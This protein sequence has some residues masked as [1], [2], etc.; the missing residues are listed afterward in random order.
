M[1]DKGSD[2]VL[3]SKKI[4]VKKYK[5]LVSK[6]DKEE[7]AQFIFERFHERY[8][9]PLKSIPNKKKNGFCIMA[10]CC[11]MIEALESFYQGWEVTSGR[12]R[13]AFENFFNRVKEFRDLKDCSSEFYEH[14]RCGILHQAETTGGW[15]IIRKGPLF[16]SN[17]LAINATEF[18]NRL[19]KYLKK[20]SDNLRSSKWNDVIWK[21]LRKKMDS[22]IKNCE[23]RQIICRTRHLLLFK[24]SGIT[25]MSLGMMG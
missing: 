18:L 4:T 1:R 17:K 11:L 24:G 16:D 22:V 13:E 20:Y 25:A 15:R 3:L 8:I 23:R 14:I 21:N 19:E 2:E 5:E 7:I 9:A 12:S 10:N 6:Q